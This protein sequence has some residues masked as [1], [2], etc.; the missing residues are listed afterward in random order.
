MKHV[1]SAIPRRII[2]TA[3]SR[4]LPL[5]AQASVANLKLLNPDFEYCFFDDAQVS[6]FIDE[7]FPQYRAT[8]DQFPHNIQRYDFFRYLA[9]YALGGFYFDTDVFLA[10][11]LAPLLG[12][13]SVFPFEE[14]TLMSHLRKLGIDWELGNYAFGAQAGHPFLK[15]LIDSCVRAQKNPASV[16]P[17]MQGIPGPFRGQF[18]VT[19]STGPGMVT[20]AF[21][22]N[23]AL[24]KT[25]SVMFPRDVCD[26]DS[27]HQFGD[28]GVHLMAGSWRGNS[29]FIRSR[30]ALQWEKRQRAKFLKDSKK[31]GAIRP[32]EWL[33]IEPGNI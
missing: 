14:L 16:E 25:V 10:R 20:R 31:L 19:N 6:A 2:Q 12:C 13:A 26:E 21:V 29:G 18:A 4:E 23:P 3:G 33:S 9:V 27:W 5:L 30:L 17:M 22:E 32:G 24:R 8:F 28:Y 15:A 7:R 1:L 11:G